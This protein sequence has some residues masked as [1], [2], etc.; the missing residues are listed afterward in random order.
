[1]IS[2]SFF[3]FFIFISKRHLFFNNKSSIVKRYLKAKKNA[4]TSEG[5]V[6]REGVIGWGKGIMEDTSC[7]EQ[8]RT[9]GGAPQPPSTRAPPERL[10]GGHPW[11]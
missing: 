2:T 4:L 6:G 10:R 3:H 9:M 5:L 7:C 8:W 11:G 1:M